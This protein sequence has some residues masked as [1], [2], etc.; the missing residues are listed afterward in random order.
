MW[1]GLILELCQNRTVISTSK[2]ELIF[3]H[4]PTL[5]LPAIVPVISRHLNWIF[6]RWFWRGWDKALPLEGNLPTPS[7]CSVLYCFLAFFWKGAS[8]SVFCMSHCHQV[9]WGDVLLAVTTSNDPRQLSR[10]S[11]WHELGYSW[12]MIGW[13]PQ[14]SSVTFHQCLTLLPG[15]VTD[16]DPGMQIR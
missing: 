11:A 10:C 6:W 7:S 9:V 16:H 15:N 14:P 4:L 8:T 13:C 12:N 2:R 1:H 5:L 3:L